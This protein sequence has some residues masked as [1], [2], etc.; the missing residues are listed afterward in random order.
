MDWSKWAGASC[1]PQCWCEATR[2]GSWILEPVN[3]WTS[4][5]FTL[6]GLYFLFSPKTFLNPNNKLGKSTLFPRLYGFSL[7]FMGVG[8]FFF[9]AS[10]T[11]VGQWFDVFGMYLITMF[12]ICYNFLRIKWF[13]DRSF[14]IIYF[15]SSL[16]L[17]VIIYFLPETRRWL[18]GATI[19]FTFFQSLWIQS[20]LKT[21][22]KH[23]YLLLALGSY[24]TAQMFWILDK[25]KIW[26]NPYAAMNGHGIWHI[27]TG[28]SALL[29][30]LYFYSEDEKLTISQEK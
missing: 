24:I 9:H 22:I 3:S 1:L 28:L 5:I 10:Q 7:V 13:N 14:L 17:G 4:L 6:I 29:I 21:Q 2:V 18:F 8:S 19:A 16:F 30:Y 27:L 20:K 15:A 23:K 26:C 11:F 25:E 12:Y